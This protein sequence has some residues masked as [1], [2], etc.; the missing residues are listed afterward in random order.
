VPR[1][2]RNRSFRSL[3]FGTIGLVYL[4]SFLLTA[5]ALA[6]FIYRDQLATW[7]ERHIDATEASARTFSMFLEQARQTL[8]I[9]GD[10]PATGGNQDLS[11]FMV[12]LLEGDE[13]ASLLEIVHVD[14]QGSV[15]GSA[16]RGT[17]LLTD[18]FAIRQSNWFERASQGETYFGPIQIA[19][20]GAPYLI[21]AVPSHDAGVV[22]ARLDM[23]MLWDLVAD[24]HF[25]DT[26]SI[27]ITDSRGRILA[28]AD[29]AIVV[30][31]T[32]IRQRQEFTEFLEE[33]A[34]T[35]APLWSGIYVNFQGDEVSGVITQLPGTH[36]LVVTEV[37]RSEIY[38]TSLRA[39]LV[40]AGGML[41]LGVLVLLITTPILDRLLFAPLEQVRQGAQRIG[42]GALD[43]RLDAEGPDEIGQLAASFNEMTA[44]LQQREAELTAHTVALAVEHDRAL[45]AS[46]L[47]SE[48][49]A[50]MSHEIR[51]PMNGI[52]GMADLLAA[53]RLTG[54]QA[55]YT[56]VIRTSADALLTVI[57]DILDLSKIEAG[58]VVLQK[59][60]FSVRIVVGEVISLLATAA[61][62]KGLQITSRVAAELPPL[63]TGDPARLRQVLLNLVGN[64]VKFTESGEVCV[65]VTYAAGTA[66]FAVQ[67]TGIGI[68]PDQVPWLFAPF[69]QAD[70]SHTRKYGGT[71]LGLAISK[72]LVELMG[73]EIGL[74]SQPGV[75][76]RFWFTAPL[77]PAAV[78][79]AVTAAAGTP[80]GGQG[81]SS[82]EGETQAQQ[83]NILLVEDNVVNQKVV[84]RQLQRLGYTAALAA[85]GREAIEAT[86]RYHYNLILMDCQ[87]PEVDGFEATRLI[88]E[89]EAPV[90]LHTPIIAMTANA[91]AGDREACLAAGM[92]DYLAKPLHIKDLQVMVERWQGSHNGSM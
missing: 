10:L 1:L 92:D 73:G 49:L 18:L 41:L 22:A 55:E 24:I 2:S 37:L 81:G 86:R 42:Q 21:I 59:E 34:H 32:S 53:T 29:P 43:H 79:P 67:D 35:Q 71:G 85:N 3:F 6:G 47:K 44:R 91:M 76:S 57:N 26:G 62:T 30:A 77:A 80:P 60:D 83:P 36:W 66:Y 50:T 23:R 87:M 8:L 88:R 64:A 20:N 82:A 90:A 75:G 28:H 33:Q 63:C 16:H 51:T 58:R 78:L 27:Y 11:P 52:I 56:Q 45:E 7:Q 31:N 48:F 65:T 84:L 46:R 68:A 70:G 15:V 4:F 54:E 39:V 5:A 17:S 74:E 25:G 89:A 12:R 40:L 72:R 14:G 9:A 69:V 19:A 13:A 61:R 38:G